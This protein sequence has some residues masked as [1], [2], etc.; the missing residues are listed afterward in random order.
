MAKTNQVLISVQESLSRYHISSS[1]EKS[2]L[3]CFK[4]SSIDVQIGLVAKGLSMYVLLLITRGTLSIAY[5]GQSI[6]FKAG[7]LHL[8]APE[9]RT[10]MLD[11]SND[12]EAYLLMLEDK[13]IAKHVSLNYIFR[14]TYLPVITL[15]QPQ[16]TLQVEEFKLLSLLLDVLIIQLAS[17][18]STKE[19]LLKSYCEI[20]VLNLVHVLE[21]S[22]SFCK[23]KDRQK[24]LFVQFLQ[25][26]PLNAVA[27]HDLAFYAQQLHITPTYLS[28]IVR[29]MSGSTAKHFIEQNLLNEA[30]LMLQH[31]DKSIT[32]IAWALNFSDQSSFTKF[33]TRCKGLSPSVYRKER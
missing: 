3:A 32:E 22:C 9:M 14:A 19:E 21:R 18:I 4:V 6:T 28:R 30:L 5:N 27:H 31:T 20:I 29:K 26:V 7:D 2:S 17:S 13:F 25:L 8:Y 23:H 33:F 16:L 12:Y 10:R 11:A 1:S 24:E 15:G